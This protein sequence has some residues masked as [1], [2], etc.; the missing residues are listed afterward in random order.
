[1]WYAWAGLRY[2]GVAHTEV[3][4][5]SEGMQQQS[6]ARVNDESLCAVERFGQAARLSQSD[7]RSQKASVNIGAAGH[8]CSMHWHGVSTIQHVGSP[9]VYAH[10]GTFKRTNNAYIEGD[11]RSCPKS[12]GAHWHEVATPWMVDV[13]RTLM[14]FATYELNQSFDFLFQN[15]I[16]QKIKNILNKTKDSNLNIWI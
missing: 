10:V 13:L 8:A 6:T 12:L 5:T 7:V 14:I 15:F 1:M 3:H 2:Q 11:S 4:Q 9:P 16:S